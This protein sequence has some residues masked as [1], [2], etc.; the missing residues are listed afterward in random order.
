MIATPAHLSSRQDEIRLDIAL[1]P[2][3]AIAVIAA[4]VLVL[5]FG[6]EIFA[7]V[8]LLFSRMLLLAALLIALWLWAIGECVLIM[9]RQ[10][11]RP[12]LPLL[13]LLAAGAAISGV[14]IGFMLWEPGKSAT[15]WVSR[16]QLYAGWSLLLF[17]PYSLIFLLI[18][19]SIVD[20]RAWN[21]TLRAQK[22]E[23]Q[24]LSML[25]AL[26]K[27]RDTDTGNHIQRTQHYVLSIARQLQAQGQHRKLLTEKFIGQL[28]R[29][30]PLHDLGK[31]AI[32]DS[33]LLKPGKLDDEEWQVMKT[34]AAIGASVLET[35]IENE[36]REGGQTHEDVLV[37]GKNIAAGHHEWWDGAGYPLG[38]KG[39]D[40]PLEAR[41][42]A[43]ADVYDAL[44]APRPYKK[45]WTHE[46][47]MAYIVEHS[48]SKFDP[49]IVNAFLARQ[50][51]FRAIAQNYAG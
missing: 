18:F 48:G 43:L 42:M 44:T 35:A 36:K 47:A 28:F 31:I 21:E 30:A 6:F 9:R 16:P 46:E 41:I 1:R 7:F 39:E 51:E 22:K 8:G 20:L 11:A 14:R 12:F 34:H 27:T 13:W 2:L 23:D 50:D 38:I 49:A 32:P 24:M 19:K 25:T 37:V 26:S 29:A 45:V 4:L 10:P 3:Q 15:D 5:S 40:I 17:I 33:I